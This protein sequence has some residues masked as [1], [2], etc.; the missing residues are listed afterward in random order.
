VPD[1]KYLW[2]MARDWKNP[3]PIIAAAVKRLNE[4]GYDTKN[5]VQVP[6][7]WP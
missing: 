5:M 7:R 4:D 3:Q 6:H 1:Q 2:I